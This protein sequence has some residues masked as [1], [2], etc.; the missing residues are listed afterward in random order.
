[1]VKQFLITTPQHDSETSYL[2][3]FSKGMIKI[4][5]DEKEIRLNNLAGAE[6]N[7]KNVEAGLSSE[8]KTLAFFNGHGDEETVFGHQDKAIL[9]ENNVELTNDKI[10]YALACRSLVRLGKVAVRKGAKAYI[11]YSED[12]MWVVERSKSAVPDKDKNAIPFRKACHVL[13]SSLVSGISVGN[14]IEK[15]K[16]EYK[17]LIRTYGSSQDNPH[18]D[19]PAIGFALA[20]DLSYLDMV[21]DN[22]ATF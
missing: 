21:G 15:T 10:V 22:D 16:Q 2:H 12:F 3:S 18:G 6:A 14:S 13:I 20:W 4:V 5:K 17:K 1:M 7:R 19:A 11:G 8:E 9:D